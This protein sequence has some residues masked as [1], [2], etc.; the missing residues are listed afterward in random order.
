MKVVDLSFNEKNGGSIEVMYKKNSKI[1]SKPIVEKILGEKLK[2]TKYFQV[3][4]KRIDNKKTLTEFLNIFP[5][6]K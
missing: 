6:K 3:I 5:Q 2:L 4:P 1:K